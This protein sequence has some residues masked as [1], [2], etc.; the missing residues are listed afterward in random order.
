MQ[1]DLI[2]HN[3][4]WISKSKIPVPHR[5]PKDTTPQISQCPFSLF[6]HISGPPES[7]WIIKK[8]QIPWRQTL[9]FLYSYNISHQAKPYAN[10]NP[11]VPDMYLSRISLQRRSLYQISVSNHQKHPGIFRCPI[12]SCSLRV[13]CESK[14]LGKPH[15]QILICIFY[16]LMCY[17]VFY[18]GLH[19]SGNILRVYA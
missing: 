1:K 3:V 13:A 6:R 2:W 11:K 9:V 5:Y 17:L 10:V 12:L 18:S 8:K 15:F 7:P 16:N 4:S 19:Y 14:R